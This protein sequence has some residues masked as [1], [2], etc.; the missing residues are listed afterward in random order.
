[1]TGPTQKGGLVDTLQSSSMGFT[2]FF[3]K[4]MLTTLISFFSRNTFSLNL[5]LSP[6][7]DEPC[8]G[9]SRMGG[10]RSKKATLSP[11][12]LT[13][14]LHWWNLAQLY[15]TWRRSKIQ[16]THKSHDTPL[17]FCWHQHFFDRKSANF[18]ISGNTDIDCILMDN[19]FNLFRTA[20]VVT[21]GSHS[22]HRLCLKLKPQVKCYWSLPAG[23]TSD[24]KVCASPG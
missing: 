24:D 10:G 12:Y 11:K 22:N 18:V 17:D 7:Q 14:I 6:I 16:K 21:N 5:L 23:W 4:E 13:Q 20:K 19:F 9:C 15:L 3:Y 8:R 2:N 1:M